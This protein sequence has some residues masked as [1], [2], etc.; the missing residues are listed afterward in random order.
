[1]NG[2]IHVRGQIEVSRAPGLT[3][4]HETERRADS[5]Q[6]RKKYILE[7]WTLAAVIV[8]AGLTWW[9][10]C[11]TK[12]AADAA[13]RAADAA[14]TSASLNYLEERAWFGPDG[15]PVVKTQPGEAVPLI[16]DMLEVR[17]IFRNTGRTPAT[18]TRIA[19]QGFIVPQGEGV[20]FPQFSDSDYS[21]GGNI[22]P[23]GAIA[24]EKPEWKE[25]LT[26]QNLLDLGA[27]T[28][29]AYIVGR[30]TYSDVVKPNITHW[31]TFCYF[32]LPNKTEFAICSPKVV[33]RRYNTFGDDAEK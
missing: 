3:N 1:M 26:A 17:V 20:G 4:E 33:D 29:S 28:H 15:T 16:H 25:P 8:Y 2:N 27:G 14:Q 24:R 30:G 21:L 23:N 19:M 18:N 7:R 22:P 11:S 10:G 12:K 32:L 9:Q 31:F 6:E 5:A 13:S